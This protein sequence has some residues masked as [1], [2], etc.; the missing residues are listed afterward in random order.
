M[1]R[2]RQVEQRRFIDEEIFPQLRQSDWQHISGKLC[3][4]FGQSDIADVPLQLAFGWFRKLD[5]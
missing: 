1:I 2:S 3:K 4:S 5:S